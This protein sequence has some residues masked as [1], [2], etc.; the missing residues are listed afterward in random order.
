MSQTKNIVCPNCDSTNRIPADR[1]VTKANCGKCKHS[2]LDTAPVELNASR[3]ERHIANSDIPVVADFWAAWCGPCKMM[4]PAFAAASGSFP[5]TA[6]FV[7]INTEAEQAL[8]ARFAIR[9]IPTLILFKNG[10]EIDRVSGALSQ[11]QLEQWVRAN[12]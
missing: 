1:T 3:F 5:L 6:R 10:R 4:A 9:S 2:L 11:P 12:L 7:K 8:S